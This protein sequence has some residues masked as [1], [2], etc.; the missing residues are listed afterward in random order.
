MNPLSQLIFAALGVL[1]LWVLCGPVLRH[2]SKPKAAATLAD[3]IKTDIDATRREV[4]RLRRT[5]EE[6]TAALDMQERRLAA[7][8][9]EQTS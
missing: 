9:T 7:L 5:V 3:T 1:A 6:R 4:Y 8:Q 2:F